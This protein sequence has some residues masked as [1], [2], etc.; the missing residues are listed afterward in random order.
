MNE[1]RHLNEAVAGI[2]VYRANYF[3]L[4]DFS[5]ADINESCRTYE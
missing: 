3:G 4:Y 2:I 5:I 1:S